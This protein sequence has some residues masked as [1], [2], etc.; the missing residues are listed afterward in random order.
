[1][2]KSPSIQSNSKS[3][4]NIDNYKKNYSNEIQD[5]IN[6]Y[7]VLI[8]Y[9]IQLIC[10]SSEI[11]DLENC[12]FLILRGVDCL[13]HI[14][15][16][17]LLYTKNIELVTYHCNKA[18]HYFVE[19]ISQIGSDSHSFLQL[20]TKDA[21]LFVYKKT[22]FDINQEFRTNYKYNDKDNFYIHNI[23]IF[24]LSFNKMI[25]I[26]IC[27]FISHNKK[28]I[29]NS[30]TILKFINEKID[31]LININHYTKNS[32]ESNETFMKNKLTII[33]FFILRELNAE[34]LLYIELLIKKINKANYET[35][36]IYN[37]LQHPDFD[38]NK[39][40]L[41]INKLIKWVLD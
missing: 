9:F 4:Y 8:K 40:K 2:I 19:F 23:K 39:R 17:L 32:L 3:L 29:F 18:S 13:A 15:N 28:D 33:D 36:K 22:I 12:K 11:K 25:N 10:E 34:D 35:K 1:M 31:L 20:N 14:Y 24:T 16:I 6:S 7:V 21:I 27:C 37:K 41:T 30:K 38:D 5:Y 26:I